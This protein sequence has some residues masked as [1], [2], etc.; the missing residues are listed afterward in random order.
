MLGNKSVWLVST[1][2]KCGARRTE[3]YTCQYALS[4]DLILHPFLY[5]VNENLFLNITFD[6]MYKIPILSL[7]KMTSSA[8]QVSGTRSGTRRNGAL[9]PGPGSGK[10]IFSVRL[11]AAENRARV[12]VAG[13]MRPGIN[14][15]L[16]LHGESAKTFISI[17]IEREERDGI[18]KV[19][20]PSLR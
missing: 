17:P 6:G 16:P 19:K 15:R 14:R 2:A 8:R 1:P 7:Y 13:F 4:I 3:L 5:K 11:T 10:N 12:W 18:A 20:S 9:R